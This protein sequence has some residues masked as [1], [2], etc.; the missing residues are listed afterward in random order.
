MDRFRNTRQP[1]WDW[2][3]QLWPTPGATLR[4]LGVTAGST[5][6]EVGCGNGYFTLPAARVT[7]PGT[8]FALDIDRSLL[9]ELSRIAHQQ[10]I[11]N[12]VPL[13]ADARDLSRLLSARVDTLLIANTFHGVANRTDFVRQAVQ[14]LRPAGRFVVVNWRD[15]PPET[16]TIA[17]EERGPPAH[18]RLSPADTAA[19]VQDAVD[20][21]LE[22][23]VALPPY[24][25]GL[26]FG[27]SGTRPD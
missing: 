12:V 16:T 23:R 3:G 8:V 4:K 22:R 25:Y 7:D 18:L 20:C 11:E 14:A 15:L 21:T 26:S 10:R 9:E 17:G 27:L 6:V 2:W 5:L 24:H 1:D 19:V 13:H